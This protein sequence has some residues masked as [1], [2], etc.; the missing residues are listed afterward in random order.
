MRI[1]ITEDKRDML[2]KTEFKI[3][4]D[5]LTP[6]RAGQTE[7]IIYIYFDEIY[8]EDAVTA[9]VYRPNTR[10]LVIY[11]DYFMSLRMFVSSKEEFEEMIKICFEELTDKL[12]RY[13]EIWADNYL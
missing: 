3:L 11:P 7:N 6:T 12:V 1:V 4:F 5:K 9:L 8:D 2:F 13:S 10:Q